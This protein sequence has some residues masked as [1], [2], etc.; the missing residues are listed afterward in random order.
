MKSRSVY[1]ARPDHPAAAEAARSQR[2]V[3]L[4]A[5]IYPSGASARTVVRRVPSASAMPAYAPAGDFEAYV[6]QHEEGYA[7]WV[8]YVAGEEPVPV[9]PET[10]T[11]RVTDRGEGPGYSGVGIVTVTVAAR[12]PQCG[13]PRGFDRVKPNRFP[14]DGAWYTA[15]IWDNSCGHVDLYADVLKESRLRPL[16]RAARRELPPEPDACTPPKPGSPAAV[17]LSFAK[18]YPGKRGGWAADVL[19]EH[20]FTEEAAKVRAEF[21]VQGGYWSAQAAAHFLHTGGQS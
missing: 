17:L 10:M 6:A 9:L 1:R 20:G 5:A 3:W 21:A 2:G 8:R 19:D 15:D 11:V 12:C 14:E 16:P 7:L 18:V 13:G 4:L